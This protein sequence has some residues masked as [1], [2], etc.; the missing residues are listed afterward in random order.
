M[1]SWKGIISVNNQRVIKVTGRSV[2]EVNQRLNRQV[3]ELNGRR[4]R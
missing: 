2:T 1:E 4:R 3:R